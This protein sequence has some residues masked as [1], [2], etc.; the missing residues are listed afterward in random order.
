VHNQIRGSGK[1]GEGEGA[2]V[3]HKTINWKIFYD[4]LRP[5]KVN[6]NIYNISALHMHIRNVHSKLVHTYSM[7]RKRQFNKMH[8][9]LVFRFF[10]KQ[11]DPA[12][13][14]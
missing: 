13:A 8:L 7:K 4:K 3:M 2:D 14:I 5:G 9:F 12:Q 1:R 11:I 10:C 6:K